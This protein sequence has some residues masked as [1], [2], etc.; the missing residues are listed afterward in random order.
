MDDFKNIVLFHI[1]IKLTD[2]Y[3]HLLT[4]NQMKG[5][6]QFIRKKG[7][8]TASCINSMVL[9]VTSTLTISTAPITNMIVGFDYRPWGAVPNIT[10]CYMYT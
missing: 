7:Y 1:K 5:K 6:K 3:G 2:S 9:W 8:L 10:L 4:S